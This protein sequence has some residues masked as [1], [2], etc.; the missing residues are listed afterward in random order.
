MLREFFG[1]ILSL[2]IVMIDVKML[3]IFTH[4]F[5]LYYRQLEGLDGIE[6][7]YYINMRAVF[8][9]T[10]ARSEKGYLSL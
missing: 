3:F 4:N 7:T 1:W 5:L 10:E 2:S 6:L 9:S 8:L